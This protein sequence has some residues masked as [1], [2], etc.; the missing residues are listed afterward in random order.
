MYRIERAEDHFRLLLPLS[1]MEK[2]GFR[3]GDDFQVEERQEGI[4]LMPTKGRTEILKRAKEKIARINEDILHSEG[5]TLEEVN[6][7]A[8][9]GM[10]AYDQRDW[11]MEEWQKKE[12]EIEKE[13]G[14]GKEKRFKSAKDLITHLH[15]LR[16]GG[17]S[18]GRG[19]SLY[20]RY[21]GV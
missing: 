6:A 19:P 20:Y 10:I 1:L 17:N 3:E 7:A 12:R 14:E 15:G 18:Y 5:L 21:G 16:N 13:I 11:W 2:F 8:K 4:F 9:A